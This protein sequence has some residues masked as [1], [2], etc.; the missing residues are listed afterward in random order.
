MGMLLAFAPFIAFAVVDRMIG[1]TQGLVAGFAV[2][3][4]LLARDWLSPD[5]APKLL[6]AGTAILFGGLACYAMLLSPAW[7][8]MG[9]RLA[10]D[11]GL[12]LIVLVSLAVRRPFTL[13]YAREQVP[14]A[15]W[16]SPEFVRTNNVITAVWALAFAALVVADAILLYVP[17]LPPR[18]GI[19]ITVLALVGAFKFTGWY[20]Q[21]RRVAA[22]NRA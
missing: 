12:L 21:R 9:V 17:E 2:S 5:R 19:L 11:S 13:Q 18:F 6:E 14:Q 16:H 22:E 7:S 20:P 1:S 15:A 3:A 8:I 4:I 10:V